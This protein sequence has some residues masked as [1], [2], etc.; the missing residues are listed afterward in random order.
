VLKVPAVI[1]GRSL[2]SALS[3]ENVPEF[4]LGG[5]GTLASGEW[6]TELLGETQ[7][8]GTLIQSEH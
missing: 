3:E 5:S 8:L 4:A 1:G 7:V 6:E 2:P